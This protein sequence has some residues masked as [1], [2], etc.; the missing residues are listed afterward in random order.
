MST[1]ATS[2][3]ALS[4]INDAVAASKDPLIG[5]KVVTAY[6]GAFQLG[7]RILTGIA[8]LQLIICLGLGR[9]VLDGAAGNAEEKENV[10]MVSI[11]EK[12]TDDK[13]DDACGVQKTQIEK[14]SAA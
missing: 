5:S 12:G 3:Y 7:Y 4:H 2:G 11:A 1:F 13:L 8:V 10:E 6:V 9:V 14:V